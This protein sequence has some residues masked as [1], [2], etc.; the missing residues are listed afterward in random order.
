MI[1]IPTPT[2]TNRTTRSYRY[3]NVSTGSQS[4]LGTTSNVKNR[5]VSF[6]LRH[7]DSKKEL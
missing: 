1:K 3:T 2:N 4:N 6:N 5:S 7:D